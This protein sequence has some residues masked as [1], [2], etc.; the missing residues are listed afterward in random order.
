VSVLQK[1]LRSARR[2]TSYLKSV[3]EYRSDETGDQLIRRLASLA[4]FAQED[5]E[6]ARIEAGLLANEMHSFKPSG[7]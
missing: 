3:D 2:F 1:A 5:F 6:E 7:Q 4:A